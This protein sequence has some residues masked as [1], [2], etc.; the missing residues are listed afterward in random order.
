MSPTIITAGTSTAFLFFPLGSTA[1]AAGGCYSDG[2]PILVYEP[3]SEPLFDPS[4]VPQYF[5]RLDGWPERRAA[6]YAPPTAARRLVRPIRH[7]ARTQVARHKRK[8]FVQALRSQ[9]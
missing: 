6:A 2:T 9:R 5:Q 1:I 3:E 7:V 8:R 4:W